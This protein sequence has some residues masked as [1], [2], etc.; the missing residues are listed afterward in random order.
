[1]NEGKDRGE[2]AADLDV[3]ASIDL[4]LGPIVF[5]LISG[6]DFDSAFESNLTKMVR[7]ALSA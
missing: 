7:R 6:Q 1:M 4:I 3:E 2:F 5:R